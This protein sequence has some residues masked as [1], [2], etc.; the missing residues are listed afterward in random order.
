MTTTIF[1][2]AGGF[3]TVR[4]V[5]SAFYE[6]VLDSPL[7]EHHFVE[8]DMRRLMDHQTKF[9][10]SLMGGPGSYTD[11]HLQ[12]VHARLGITHDEFVEAA[13]LLRETLEE[14]GLDAA[15]IR[16]VD[17]EVMK[18]ERVIVSP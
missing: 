15:D 2:R 11:D 6:K 9:V 5:I 12:R 18:R 7:L 3:A 13:R 1:D 17:G 14:F 4:K 8:V 10:S 16:H